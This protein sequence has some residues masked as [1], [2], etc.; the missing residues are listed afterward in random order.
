MYVQCIPLHFDTSSDPP[1]WR[2]PVGGEIGLAKVG[3]HPYGRF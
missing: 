3:G 1:W 2:L